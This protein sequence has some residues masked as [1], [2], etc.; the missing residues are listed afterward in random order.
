MDLAFLLQAALLSVVLLCPLSF[1][2]MLAWSA[3]SRRRASPEDTPDAPA[4]Q[5]ATDESEVA[6]MRARLDAPDAK[7]PSRP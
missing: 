7:A 4:E 1:V 3:W 2:A 6:R 5:S